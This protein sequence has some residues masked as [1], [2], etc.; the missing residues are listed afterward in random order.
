MP[1]PP[2]RVFLSYRREDSSG[3][4]GRLYDHLVWRLPATDVFRDIDGIKAGVDFVVAIE[5]ALDTCDVVL[6][7][8][9]QRWLTVT[10]TLGAAG[11]MRQTTSSAWRSKPRS[12]VPTSR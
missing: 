8:I 5:R 4:A 7:I 3:H 12:D 9:G 2:L 1:E 10:A 6:V 11:S